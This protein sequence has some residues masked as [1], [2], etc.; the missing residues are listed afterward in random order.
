MEAVHITRDEPNQKIE[1]WSVGEKDGQP[2]RPRGRAGLSAVE[3]ARHCQAR[4][5]MCDR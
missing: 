1:V 3:K 5:A 2:I 4:K